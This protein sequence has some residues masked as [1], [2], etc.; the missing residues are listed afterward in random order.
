MADTMAMAFPLYATGKIPNVKLQTL[1][2]YYGISNENA[3]QAMVDI[4]RTVKVYKAL[5]TP[6]VA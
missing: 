6:F 4:E 3:H 2:D 5:M 1:C